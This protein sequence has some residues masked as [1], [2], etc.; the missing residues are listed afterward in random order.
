MAVSSVPAAAEWKPDRNIEFIVTSGPGGGTDRFAR[1]VQAAITNN[2]LLE[3]SITVVNKPGANGAEGL[4]TLEEAKG[5]PHKVAFGTSN[6]WMLPLGAKVAYAATDLTPLAIMAFDEFI[7]WVNADLPYKSIKEYLD[8][9]RATPGAIKMGGGMTKDVDHILTKVIENAAHVTF[10]YVP[11]KG[12]G[13]AGIQLAGGHITS[14]VNNPS[15]NIEHWRSGKVRPLCVVSPKRMS[16]TEKVTSDMGWA[17]IPTCAEAGL[18]VNEFRGPRTVWLAGGL[19]DEQLK[20]YTVLFGKVR[21]T[22]EWK[23]FITSAE[24]SDVY[25][26]GKEFADFMAKDEASGRSI[27]TEAGWLVK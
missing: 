23:D 9:A 11:F 24:L 21:E 20:F 3:S 22:K 12:G 2:K 25:V 15:E 10:S 18:P 7:I 8:A 27:F 13:D 26:T 1:A 5:N 17:D 4:L 6:V 14:N 16:S 19:T